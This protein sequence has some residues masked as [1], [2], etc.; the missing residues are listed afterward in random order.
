MAELNRED[1]FGGVEFIDKLLIELN[2]IY[3]PI[4]PGPKD[5]IAKIM[6]ESGQRSVVEYIQSKQEK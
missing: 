6:Y 4:T 2:T 1:V 5:S 3:P